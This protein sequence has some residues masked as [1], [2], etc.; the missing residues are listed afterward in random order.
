MV[1]RGS[2]DLLNQSDVFDRTRLNT[3]G[4]VS[5]HP[6]P[7]RERSIT[8]STLDYHRRLRVSP[9][10][11]EHLGVTPGSPFNQTIPFPSQDPVD[12]GLIK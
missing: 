6:R 8:G 3:E 2:Y 1:F 11:P 7:S 5:D 10:L 9:T 12:T 4:R